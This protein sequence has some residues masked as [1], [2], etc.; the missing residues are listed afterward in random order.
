[1]LDVGE[2]A[3]DEVVDRNDS[4]TFREEAIGQVRAKKPGPTGDNGNG[5]ITGARSHGAFYLAA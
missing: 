2:M 4:M 5:R 3:G 1:V